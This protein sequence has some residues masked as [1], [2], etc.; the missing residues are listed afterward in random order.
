MGDGIAK[1][2]LGLIEHKV[3]QGWIR[4]LFSMLGSGILTFM[5][6]C[7]GSLVGVKT[8]VLIFGASVANALPSSLPAGDWGFSVGLGFV[9]SAVMMIAVFRRDPLS[10][11]IMFVLPSW[12]AAA[13]L[14]TN[15]EV[16]EPQQQKEK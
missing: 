14:N 5:L 12:E 3:L 1:F 15:I 16:I 4:L 7:G 6:V 8:L 9:F 2:V 10:K 11:G 13:E